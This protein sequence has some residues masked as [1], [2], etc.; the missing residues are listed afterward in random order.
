MK[1]NSN[2]RFHYLDSLRGLAALAVFYSHL[3][4]G[5]NLPKSISFL[6]STPIHIFWHGEGAVVFF[7]LLSGFVLSNQ[8]SKKENIL[9][10]RNYLKYVILRINRIYPA[11][12]VMIII[13]YVLRKYLDFKI[14]E[15]AMPSQWLTGIVKAPITI[16]TFFKEITVVAPISS[17]QRILPHGWTLVIEILISIIFPFLFY[18]SKTSKLALFIFTIFS[19]KFLGFHQSTIVFVCGIY[20]YNYRDLITSS[21]KKFSKPIKILILLLGWFL[22][23]IGFYLPQSVIIIFNKVFINYLLPGCVLLFISVM[24]SFRIKKIMQNTFLLYLGKISYSLYLIHFN[25]ILL[26]S[27]YVQG[28]IHLFISKN[29]IVFYCVFLLFMTMIVLLF[30]AIFYSLIEKPMM[31]YGRKYLQKKMIE[32]SRV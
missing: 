19:I 12:L 15:L 10:E 9:D 25:I 22:F 14:D 13:S 23:T 20:L 17:E 11:F 18:I 1:E 2:E 4:G 28:L 30:S 16:S 31:D 32:K 8:L 3:I 26:F 6:G 24:F 29:G 7:F 21:C 5:Y 27:G